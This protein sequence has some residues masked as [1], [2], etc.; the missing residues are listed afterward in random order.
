MGMNAYLGRKK[1]SEDI[2]VSKNNIKC[3]YQ[4][5]PN[6][7]LLLGGASSEIVSGSSL[8]DILTP[9]LDYFNQQIHCLRDDT[10]FQPISL[11]T[12]I[13]LSKI[14]ETFI[15]SL[16]KHLPK[17]WRDE[18]DW[19]V[20]LQLEGSSAVQAAVDILHQYR[21]YHMDQERESP[22]VAVGKSS[23]HGPSATSFG[24]GAG[25]PFVEIR[26]ITYPVPLTK[27]Q[28][29]NETR[30]NFL[31][32]ITRQQNEF[33]EK[34]HSDIS[35]LLIEPQWGSGGEGQ[36]WPVDILKTFVE[37]ARNYG[38]LVISDEIMCGLGRHGRGKTFLID[39]LNIEVDAILFGKSIASGAFPLSGAVI[40]KGFGFFKK[41]GIVPFQSH[42]YSH[43]ANMLSLF[44]A[45]QVLNLLPTFHP[46]IQTIGE[47]IQKILDKI[48]S[49]R[50]VAVSGQGCL[51]GIYL[52]YKKLSFTKKCL[53][54]KLHDARVIVYFIPDGILLTPIY[55]AELTLVAQALERLVKAINQLLNEN[56]SA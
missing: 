19:A 10:L 12:S 55:N 47:C 43:G 25:S 51:W 52:D 13:G 32:R 46:K 11:H 16:E 21:S 41:R 37:T 22:V 5:D 40:R 45:V 15:Q 33:L 54:K 35:I 50:H 44:S 34:H 28:E 24:R 42:T 8:A 17:S 48:V 36:Y 1:G 38:I 31:K 26:Q 2:L 53:Q 9:T 30:H 3:Y 4:N 56:K 23:Y 18:D 7:Y 14:L 39:S 49:N 27:Y 29:E 20:S 6:P